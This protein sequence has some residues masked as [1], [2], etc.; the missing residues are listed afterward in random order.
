MNAEGQKRRIRIGL[1]LLMSPNQGALLRERNAR[2]RTGLG[3]RVFGH[4][5]AGGS[6][7]W[8]SLGRRLSCEPT[9]AN[10]PLCLQMMPLR[11]FATSC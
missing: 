7:A 10:Y 6:I 2:I 11:S 5:I 3:G 4:E 1:G 8:P 9:A